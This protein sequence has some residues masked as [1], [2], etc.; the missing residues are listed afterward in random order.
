[1]SVFYFFFSTNLSIIHFGSLAL[2]WKSERHRVS[3]QTSLGNYVVLLCSCAIAT[4]KCAFK[5]FFHVQTGASCVLSSGTIFN[6]CSSKSFK[7]NFLQ[8]VQFK[9]FKTQH[10]HP[11]CRVM[12]HL[13]WVSSLRSGWFALNRQHFHGLSL[14]S[15]KKMGEKCDVTAARRN[16][17]PSFP[18]SPPLSQGQLSSPACSYQRVFLMEWCR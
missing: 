3:I 17:L 18:P 14:I 1:M 16:P 7:M 2:I 13:N 10:Y 11:M 15:T 12:L 4:F 5:D 8:M 6:Q 9:L